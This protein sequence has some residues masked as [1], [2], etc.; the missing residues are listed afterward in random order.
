LSYTNAFSTEKP[1]KIKVD[2][3][4]EKKSRRFSGEIV[5]GLLLSFILIVATVC[6]V[7][8]IVQVDVDLENRLKD[9]ENKV[10]V[11]LDKVQ[12]LKERLM[13]LE[14]YVEEKKKLKQM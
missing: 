12:S 6:L 14:I 9:I 5:F 3:E 2:Q 1:V 13:S 10:S 11:V 7:K 8:C 4:P